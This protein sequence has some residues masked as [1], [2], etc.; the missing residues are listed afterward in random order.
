LR[1]PKFPLTVRHLLTH[2][3]GFA[4]EFLNRELAE[5][6]KSGKVA[7][8][9]SGTADFLGAPLV[10]DPGARW[11]YGISTDWLGKLVEAVTGQTLEARFRETIFNPL[12]MSDTGYHVA[13]DKQ[14][15][16]AGRFARQPT[17]ELKSVPAPPGPPKY[18][19]G[20]GG[21][22]STAADYLRFARALLRGGELDGSRILKADTVAMIQ[23]NHIGELKLSPIVALNPQ[24][25]A[26]GMQLPGAP[27]AFGLGFALNRKPMGS[28]RGAGTMSWAGLHNTFFWIDREKNLC[29]VLLLQMLPFGDPAALQLV[30][31][32]EREVYRV[33]RP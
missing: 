4:Y 24:L 30:N 11:E 32:F 15:R 23:R 9:F 3:S 10:A 29:A 7:S 18:V 5:H 17:G 27:D 21:L 14:R 16:S 25:V 2:T 12:K 6:V 33:F 20:G 13:P 19:L 31:D 1:P 22:Q 8:A 26:A 28:T